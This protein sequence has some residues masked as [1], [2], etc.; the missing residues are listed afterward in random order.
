MVKAVLG[1]VYPGHTTPKEDNFGFTVD[2]LKGL[3]DSGRLVGKPIWL[4]HKEPTIGEINRAWVDDAGYL[5][6]W[7]DLYDAERLGNE[8]LYESVQS[9]IRNKE[10]KDFS[11]H[12]VGSR[13]TSGRV[14]QDSKTFLEASLTTEGAYKNTSVFSQA[15]SKDS[16]TTVIAHGHGKVAMDIGEVQ[17][18]ISD[19][20]LNLDAQQFNGM[21]AAQIAALLLGEVAKAKDQAAKETEAK[22]APQASMTD[23]DRAE[24][25]ELRKHREAQQKMMEEEKK[26]YAE[27]ESKN[28]DPVFEGIKHL[29]PE[30]DQKKFHEDLSMLASETSAANYWSGFKMYSELAAKQKQEI[31]QGIKEKVKLTKDYNSLLKE[32]REM[33]MAKTEPAAQPQAVETASKQRTS[34]SVGFKADSA[35][36]RQKS[37]NPQTGEKVEEQASLFAQQEAA[38]FPKAFAT[39]RGYN[40]EDE[41]ARAFLS[42]VQEKQQ[43][44]TLGA[45]LP[46][47]T[48]NDF[49][50]REKK[51]Q[52]MLPY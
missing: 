51:Y 13:D 28:V 14:I 47:V 39:P 26:K 46:M 15:A 34:G 22:L 45:G 40:T 52:T 29:V 3:V 44:M 18:M 30:E 2:E 35:P 7:A 19:A 10:L 12:W 6:I 17:Q 37:E 42:F 23:A 5:C 9:Q 25:E 31:E 1:R 48:Q 27:R 11:I 38:W 16:N 49:M 8:E 50:G 32:H 41:S 4:E 21:G 20:G 43:S 33:K 24:L 36:K